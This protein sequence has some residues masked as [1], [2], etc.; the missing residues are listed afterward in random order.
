METI[1]LVIAIFSTSFLL[2][3][4]LRAPKPSRASAN[5]P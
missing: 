4:P 5:R 2:S 1:L 3:F